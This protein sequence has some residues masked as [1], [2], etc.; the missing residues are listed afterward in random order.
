MNLAEI[1]E[2]SRDWLD[3]EEEPFLYPT[4]R[5]ER[6]ADEAQTEGC[7]RTR[8]LFDSQDPDLCSIQLVAGQVLYPLNPAILVVRRA[9]YR[10]SQVGARP[11]VLRRTTFGQLDWEDSS[12]TT[13]TGKPEAIVQDLQQ[14]TL[15][16]SH[17][18]PANPGTL[19]LTVWR[20]PLESEALET[21]SDEPLLD[22]VSH[23]YLVH[24]VCYRAFLKMDGE[25][26]NGPL[27]AEHL[28]QFEQHFGPRP[29][30]AQLRA[31]ATDDAGE[32]R[33]HWY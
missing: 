19:Q 29:T 26:R 21:A 17:I 1:I 5:L 10:P 27:A 23:M 2:L 22:T 13:R 28:A 15:R 30:A 16:L 12:W 6:Y 32:V 9:E 8:A 24:W 11:C 31:L 25:A 3:D 14:R 7:I 4:P 18:P 33:P 20:K